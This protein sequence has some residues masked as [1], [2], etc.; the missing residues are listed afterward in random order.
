M[1]LYLFLLI[2]VIFLMLI[3]LIIYHS[4]R[5]KNLKLSLGLNKIIL[6]IGV[7]KLVYLTHSLKRNMSVCDLSREL[8]CQNLK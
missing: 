8:Y 5:G 6:V 4:E 3:G 2:E 1:K 7:I